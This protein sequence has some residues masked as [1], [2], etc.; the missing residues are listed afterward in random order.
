MRGSARERWVQNLPYALLIMTLKLFM[1]GLLER[2]K[3]TIVLMQQKFSE[4]YHENYTYQ[5][6]K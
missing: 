6:R 4:A 1:Y 5:N 3:N 2:I